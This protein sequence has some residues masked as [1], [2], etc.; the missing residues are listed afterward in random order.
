LNSPCQIRYKHGKILLVS[1]DPVFNE[2]FS[3]WMTRERF[4][5]KLVETFE[6]VI[7][8]LS[9]ERFN[10]V[11]PTNMWLSPYEMPAL[12]SQIRQDCPQVGILVISGWTGIKEEVLLR[13][14]QFR[15]APIP[16]KE[17]SC[18]VKS[19]IAG[20]RK[21]ISNSNFSLQ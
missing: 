18:R 20:K 5:F 8:A 12:V 2:I 4:D 9:R 7:P 21:E 11:V 15:K 13:G 6:E 19:I 1:R 16:L 10:V 14:G 17:F 3:S